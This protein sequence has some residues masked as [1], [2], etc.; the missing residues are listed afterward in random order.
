MVSDN[1][2]CDS[3]SAWYAPSSNEPLVDFGDCAGLS[4][5]CLEAM[6]SRHAP[7]R[8]LCQ[9]SASSD[10]RKATPGWCDRDDK[11]AFPRSVL[12]G[13]ARENRAEVRT[14]GLYNNVGQFRRHFSYMKPTVE[15][16]RRI[17][18]PGYETCSTV[19]IRRHSPQRCCSISPL[20]AASCSEKSAD[21]HPVHT[22]LLA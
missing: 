19:P 8:K 9:R 5:H 18:L 6:K 10:L 13:I 11:W 17:I 16:R 7:D 1:I 14:Y 3:S 15:R 12:E 4:G 2:I 22:K 20:R 21:P